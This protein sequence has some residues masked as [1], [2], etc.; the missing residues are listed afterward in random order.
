[1]PRA[2]LVTVEDCPSVNL[3][4]LPLAGV[5]CVQRRIGRLQTAALCGS[6]AL[7]WSS[8]LPAQQEYLPRH[9]HV[10]LRLFAASLSRRLQYH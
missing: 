3:P 2:A 7:C 9:G 1:M 6:T 8:E 10:H 5:S 4:I